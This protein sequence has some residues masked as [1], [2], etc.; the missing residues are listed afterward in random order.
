MLLVIT[1]QIWAHLPQL[2]SQTWSFL[3]SWA[4]SSFKRGRTTV[5]IC[6]WLQHLYSMHW[7]TGSLMEK[8]AHGFIANP[9]PSSYREQSQ[10]HHAWLS[11]PNLD[12]SRDPG[13]ELCKSQDISGHAAEPPEIMSVGWIKGLN[14]ECLAWTILNQPCNIL[15][16]CNTMEPYLP[17]LQVALLALFSFE[18]RCFSLRRYQVVDGSSPPSSMQRHGNE[19]LIQAPTPKKACVTW[20]SSRMF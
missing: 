13:V 20:S 17:L 8:G 1:W 16:W 5:D 9:S 14:P 19:Y 2:S 3:V 11:A 15:Q 7:R 6:W 4:F 10:T 12:G 18:I